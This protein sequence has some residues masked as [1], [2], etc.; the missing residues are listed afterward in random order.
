MQQD[1]HEFFNFI[2]NAISEALAEDKKKES[3]ATTSSNRAVKNAI[4]ISDIN[5]HNTS[6]SELL[7]RYV[8]ISMR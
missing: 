7:S 8:N 2:L 3:M 1:A 5:K 4:N 6:S